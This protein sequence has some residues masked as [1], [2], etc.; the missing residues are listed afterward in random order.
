MTRRR[1]KSIDTLQV[2]Y[3]QH[4]LSARAKSAT[5]AL[6]AVSLGRAKHF[7]K[8]P[9]RGNNRPFAGRV[10]RDV[11]TNSHQ[12]RSASLRGQALDLRPV[13]LQRAAV[14]VKEKCQSFGP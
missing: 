5:Q 4:T 12:L 2:Y 7:V 13:F 8:T 11:W 10:Y 6:G 1:S 9:D 3:Q 14:I